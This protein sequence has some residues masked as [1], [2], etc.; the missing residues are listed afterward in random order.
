MN[1]KI[2][3]D[4]PAPN[5][6]STAPTSPWPRVVVV[7]AGAVGGYFG[8]RLARA[9][10]PVTLIGRP[11]LIEA[12]HR[13][14]FCLEMLACSETLQVKA[15]CDMSA[16]HGADIVLFC[17]KTIDTLA[18]AK[19]LAPFITPTT[20]VLCLQNG[21]EN[22]FTIQAC[23]QAVVVQAVVYLAASVPQPGVVK[24]HGR[25]DLII[26]PTGV[27]ASRLQTLFQH[28]GVTCQ[29]SDEI[30]G[31][32]WEKFI[33]NCSLNAISALSHRTYGE[34]G[35]QAEAWQLVKAVIQETLQIAAAQGIIPSNMRDLREATATVRKLTRQIAG[36][37]SSTAQDL[38]RN[39]PT[40]IDSLNG[41]IARQGQKFGIPVP[42][43][44][45]LYS[46]VKSAEAQSPP[47]QHLS[48]DVMD[49]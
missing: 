45:A 23:T 42:V 6:N 32:L 31:H 39:K 9:G 24:H 34:I 18:V 1:L 2:M 7:G 40:E 8:G 5:P 47:I 26:G 48:K 16:A 33:C 3:P 20:I 27:A 22:V 14:G 29:I 25:G 11:A 12:V 38:R 49:R 21:V 13:S 41:F 44:Q 28:A 35:E 43:N 36:A 4:S 10:V 46:L 37:Y 15:S 19:E 30:E 17:V